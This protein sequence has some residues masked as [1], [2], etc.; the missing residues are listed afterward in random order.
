MFLL[1][2]ILNSWLKDSLIRVLYQWKLKSRC[3]KNLRLNADTIL[4]TNSLKCLLI[5]PYQR[6]WW[7]NS[8]KTQS[9]SRLKPWVLNLIVRFLLM[10]T[11]PNKIKVHAHYQKS[12]LIV[13]IFLKSSTKTNIKTDIYH[14][15]INM[16]LLSYKLYSLLKN[17]YQFAMYIKQSLSVYSIKA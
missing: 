12:F 4:S 16:V 7:S 3:F 2:L 5:W 17:I 13:E 1:N 6:I 9:H 10:G 15:Y 14:G 8:K 11:G